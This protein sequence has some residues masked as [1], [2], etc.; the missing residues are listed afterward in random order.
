MTEKTTGSE[1]IFT[2]PLREAYKKAHDKRLP[3]AARL[4]RSY[5]K[6]HMKSD[7]VKLGSRLNEQLWSRGI[8]RPPRSVRVKAFEEDGVVK[9]ELMGHDYV[10]FKAKPKKERKD[11]KEKLM[12]RLGPKAIKKEEE[13]KKIDSAGKAP[14]TAKPVERHEVGENA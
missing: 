10:D 1:K 4:V 3:Y 5:L 14:E 13:D 11:M 8:S 9:A 12:E 2:I 7:T 6:T